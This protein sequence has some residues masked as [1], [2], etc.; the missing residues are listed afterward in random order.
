V[1]PYFVGHPGPTVLF[2]CTI[3]VWILI[4]VRQALQR[5]PEASSA[6][7]GSL[8]IVWLWTTVALVVASVAVGRVPGAAAS[9]GG[10]LFGIGVAL[11]W[12]GISLRVWAFQ[13]LGRYFTFTVMTSADQP[14]VTTGPYRFVRHPGYAG[15]V[16]LLTG[17]GA[18]YGNWLSLAALALVPLIGFIHRIHV[19]EAALAANLGSAYTSYASGRKRLIPFVW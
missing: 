9:N 16:L 2:A 7:R 1:K 18:T 13:T 14:V 4:E 15:L 10:A 17:I 5:R 19:E 11:M 3:A 12:G 6:D 8:L